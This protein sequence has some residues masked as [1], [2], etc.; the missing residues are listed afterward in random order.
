MIRILLFAALIFVAPAYARAQDSREQINISMPPALKM[1]EISKLIPPAKRAMFTEIAKPNQM[2]ASYLSQADIDIV[3]GGSS[4]LPNE[5]VIVA[6]PEGNPTVTLAEFPKLKDALRPNMA[7]VGA[8]T[9]KD[10]PHWIGTTKK[11]QMDG[12]TYLFSTAVISIKDYVLMLQVLKTAKTGQD[13]EHLH[14]KVEY[15]VSHLLA[16]NINR[17]APTNVTSPI[18]SPALSPALSPV[19]PSSQANKQTSIKPKL[20]KPKLYISQP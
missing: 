17:A 7:R 16:E 5:M 10:S 2:L 14:Q 15:I 11:H 6:V 9:F 4:E 13:V 19:Q 1:Q 12:K 3:M 20:S 8:V 18:P